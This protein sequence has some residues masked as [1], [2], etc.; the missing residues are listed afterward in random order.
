MN[1]FYT[2]FCYGIGQEI[3]LK[4]MFKTISVFLAIIAFFACSKEEIY[5]IPP[6]SIKATHVK[7]EQHRMESYHYYYYSSKSQ[8]AKIVAQVDNKDVGYVY[9]EYDKYDR[10]VKKTTKTE[11]EQDWINYIYDDKGRVIKESG[12][13]EAWELAYDDAGRLKNRTRVMGGL[14][15][16]FKYD[17]LYPDRISEELLWSSGQIAEHLKYEYNSQGQLVVKKLI[18]GL[19]HLDRGTKEFYVYD[20]LGRISSKLSYNLNIYNGFGLDTTERYYYND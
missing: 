9:F 18:D 14:E 2:K 1:S 3:S 6:G 7:Y 12:S 15:Y 4:N 13:G 5:I 20:N 17:S 19:L 16:E 10:L 8:L 11:G